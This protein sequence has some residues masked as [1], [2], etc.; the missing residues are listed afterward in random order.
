MIVRYPHCGITHHSQNHKVPGLKPTDV[1]SRA[2]EPN[3]ITMLKLEIISAPFRQ[4]D[5][6]MK[7]ETLLAAQLLGLDTQP[8]YEAPGDM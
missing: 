3:L 5:K 7:S 1:F 4:S 2:V 6:K 8:C